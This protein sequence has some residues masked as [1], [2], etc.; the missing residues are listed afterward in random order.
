MTAEKG[1]WFDWQDEPTATAIRK[2]IAAVDG[3]AV[4]IL[5]SV[6][7]LLDTYLLMRDVNRFQAFQQSLGELFR[8]AAERG[9]EV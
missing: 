1:D 2:Q 4:N 3:A 6:K 5:K 8:D 9:M 7:T